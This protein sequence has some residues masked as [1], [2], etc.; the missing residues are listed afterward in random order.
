MQQFRNTDVMT[1]N[2]R[3]TVDAAGVIHIQGFY[4]LSGVEEPFCQQPSDF[5][6]SAIEPAFAQYTQHQSGITDKADSRF[7][8]PSEKHS[9]YQDNGRYFPIAYFTIF[10]ALYS[11]YF[12]FSV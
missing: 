1:N 11:S 5:V 12:S 3:K 7:D 6:H 9:R 10:G 8:V 2:H 4:C